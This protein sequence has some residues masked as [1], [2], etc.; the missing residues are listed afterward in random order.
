MRLPYALITLL[1]VLF[2]MSP[3]IAQDGLESSTP[4]ATRSLTR[5]RASE[6]LA[7]GAVLSADV[8]RQIET[9]RDPYEAEI[10][11][12]VRD[13]LADSYEWRWYFRD[14]GILLAIPVKE[15][16]A[17]L[18]GYDREQVFADVV[19][20]LINQKGFGNPP[21]Q[22][23][24]VEPRELSEMFSTARF[25]GIGLDKS[26]GGGLGGALSAGNPGCECH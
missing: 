14:G 1:S 12:D 2:P 15:R 13:V 6:I 17:L 11:D 20:R 10:V 9:L 23:V 19:R 26:L 18:A 21:V 4:T 8:A 7:S 22:V 3:V 24:F 16:L 25:R 5:G